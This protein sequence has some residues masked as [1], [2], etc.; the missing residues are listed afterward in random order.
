MCGIAG[1]VHVDPAA[2]ID[3]DAL[4][5]MCRSL[6]HR[7]PD[8]S[9][10]WTGRGAG[11][12][13]RRLS[14]IDLSPAGRQ[15]MSNEDGSVWVVFNG[16]IYNFPELRQGLEER[17]HAFRS[18]TDS[19]VIVHL[20]EELGEKCVDRLEGMFALALWDTR[21]RRLVLARD[22]VGKKPLKYA[23]T[24]DGLVF[25]SELKAILAAGFVSRDVSRKDIHTF[26]GIGYVPAPGT[27]FE[28]IRKLPAGHRLVWEDGQTRVERF[29][30][31]DFR[32]KQT[33]SDEEWKERVRD[34]VRRAVK[35]RLISDVP[36][37]VFLSG[38]IDSSIVAACMARVSD[39]PVKTFSM[40]FEFDRY[41][42]LPFARQVAEMYGT[43]HREF[44]TRAD[45][46][47]LLPTLAALYEEPYCDPSAVPSYLL[48]RE[49][50][51]HVTVV[52]NGDGGDEGFCGY[53]RYERIASWAARLRL[54]GSFGLGA[55]AKGAADV[56]AGPLPELSMKLEAVQNLAARDAGAWYAWIVRL[57]SA[58]QRARLYRTE[59]LLAVGRNGRG[60]IAPLLDDP[61]GGDDLIDRMLY[62]DTMCYLP[63]DLLPKMDL[64]SMAWGLEARSPLLDHEVLELAASAPATVK[65]RGG[66]LKWLLKEAFRDELPAGIL[67]REKQGFGIPLDEWLR[68]P[69]LP[70]ARD[71][72]TAS[73]SR[74]HAYMQPA[75]V[76]GLVERHAAGER[77]FGRQLWG[78]L[79][80]EL[81]H[82]EVVEAAAGRA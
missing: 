42:E 78:L 65:F 75:R 28:R 20:Y 34:T 64:A 25:A 24:P 7:G 68:G 79:M 27:G 49:T 71:L 51:K 60:P 9:G 80:L 2:S 45:A 74:I 1:M 57:F 48:S 19:E 63:E 66:Q 11:L 53:T 69:L 31:L 15:P 58:R 40:G 55:M 8:D 14:I 52:L 61:H 82:R 5:R 13:H 50:R 4:E 81:W 77:D 29:W 35:K 6:A 36:L 26:L 3:T 37:G 46:A 38:G 72:L 54:A 32:H 17:G 70:L 22:R 44:V 73:D 10:V 41:D 47:E 16:E 12:G 18:R 30:S 76:A 43:E 62:A 67:D 56:L 39:E 23:E 33:L 21:R 59:T